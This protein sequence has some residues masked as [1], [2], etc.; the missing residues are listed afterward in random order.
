[1]HFPPALTLTSHACRINVFLAILNDAYAGVKG[2]I[3]EKKAQDEEE[4]ARRIAEEGEP[5]RK[6]VRERIAALRKVARGRLHR[7]AGRLKGMSLRRRKKPLT[8]TEAVAM[9]D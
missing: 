6:S 5:E 9:M 1:M 4:K 3:E 8:V 2:D 7:F